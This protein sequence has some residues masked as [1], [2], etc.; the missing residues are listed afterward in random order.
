MSGLLNSLHIGQSSIFANQKN[1]S[2]IG[3]NVANAN[4]DGYSRQEVEMEPWPTVERGGLS[5]GQGVKL[6]EIARAH[7]RFVTDRLRDASEELGQAEGRATPLTELE[8]I[9]GIDENSVAGAMDDFFDAWHELSVNP[10]GEA[11]RSMVIEQGKALAT[12]F[13]QTENSMSGLKDSIDSRLETDLENINDKLKQIADLN[14]RITR[15][16]STGHNPNTALDNRD[17]LLQELSQDI[18]SKVYIDEKGSASVYLPQGPTLVQDSQANEIQAGEQTEDGLEFTL[19]SGKTQTTLQGQ[20]FG[21]EFKGYIDVRDKL[22][23]EI[24]DGLDGLKHDLI[25]QVNAK[26]ADGVDLNGDTG[27]NF[28]EPVT[29]YQSDAHA[30]S[31]ENFADSSGTDDYLTLEVDGTTTD[32]EI[33]ASDTLADIRDKMND[34]VDGVIASVVADETSDK[35]KLKVV[36]TN[37]DA[38]VEVATANLNGSNDLMSTDDEFAA[39]EGTTNLQVAVT[40]PEDVAAG[41]SFALGDNETALEIAELKDAQVAGANNSS[42]FVDAYGKISSTVGV[43]VKQ[44]EFSRESLR[45]TLNQL[46]NRRDEVAGVS[47]DES[48][49]DLQRYQRAFQAS[50]Q[51]VTTV[52]EMMQTLLGIKR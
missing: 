29:S 1:M 31:V 23:P 26:H 24:E 50:A 11:E 48:M 2:V 10:E 22:L 51:Y 27:Q 18:G 8:R 17:R 28:F 14:R 47:I 4:T 37:K 5:F 35:F 12:R 32:V 34:Q 41:K 16:T 3:N 25:T 30:W 20:D 39:V 6:G 45:D 40:N 44:N 43:E 49:I 19:K 13:R 9:I 33:D 7:D 38:S 46:E 15:A 52:D 42:T 21:G 36:P